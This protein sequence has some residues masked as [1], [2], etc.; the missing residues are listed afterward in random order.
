MQGLRVGKGTVLPSCNITWPHQV[1]LGNDCRLEPNIFF[2][3][4]GPWKPGPSIVIGND[5]FIGRGC[6]FN[7]RENIH[8]GNNCLISSETK[9][10]DHNHG[11]EIGKPMNRQACPG[12]PIVLE[13]DVWIGVNTV[14]LKGVRISK[15][16]V[17]GAGAVVT[18]SIPSN[19]IWCGVPAKKIGARKP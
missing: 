10:I 1:S 2:K 11:T 16:A 17:V 14:I 7:I 6:E 9:F 5:V 3:F 8:I 12:T 13:E 19:E 18:S 4:D 15:G